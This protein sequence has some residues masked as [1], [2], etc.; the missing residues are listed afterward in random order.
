[1]SER[2]TTVRVRRCVADLQQ[3]EAFGSS[4]LDTSLFPKFPPSDIDFV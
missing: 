1:M 2:E 3:K 4:S